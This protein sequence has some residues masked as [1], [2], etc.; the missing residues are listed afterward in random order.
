MAEELNRR[1]R[2]DPADDG[3]ELASEA[4]FAHDGE[5]DRRVPGPQPRDHLDQHVEPFFLLEPSHRA[6]HHV[7][8]RITERAANGRAPRR[9]APK[10]LRIDRV[11]DDGDAIGTRAR[12]HELGFDV[13]RDGDD[14]WEAREQP[15]LDRVVRP[16]AEAHH[17]ETV[18]GRQRDDRRAFGERP[19]EPVGLVVVRVDDVDAPIED[20]LAQLR[21][22]PGV[23]RVALDDLGVVEAELGGAAIEREDFVAS[24][25][26]V[27]DGESDARRIVDARAVQDRLVGPAA[28]A[29]HAAELEH[30]DWPA[31]VI[32]TPDASFGAPVVRWCAPGQTIANA[33]ATS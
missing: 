27:A 7:I 8:V 10:D 16:L 18:R 31:H 24:I 1:S 23:E 14:A 20:E 15:L 9:V 2:A 6:D 32:A 17:G 29:P 28:R 30:T 12:A 3:F 11:V 19:G 26:D 33:L 4:A 13:A 22:D 25:A 21:P 5:L